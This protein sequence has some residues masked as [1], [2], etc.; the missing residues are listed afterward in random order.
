MLKEKEA[1]LENAKEDA[2]A[3]FMKLERDFEAGMTRKIDPTIFSELT[4]GEFIVTTG[5]NWNTI[6]DMV[7]GKTPKDKWCYLD[8]TN[9]EGRYQLMN[10]GPQLGILRLMELTTE[11]ANSYR[12][13]CATVPPRIK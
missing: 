4:V 9:Y 10:A 5:F 11:K 13:H 8:R 2:L 6:K 7:D 12:K 3:E 1:E